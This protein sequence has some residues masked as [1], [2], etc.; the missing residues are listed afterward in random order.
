LSSSKSINTKWIKDLYIGPETLK[1]EQE[2]TGNTLEAICIGND[3]LSRTQMAQPVRKRIDKWDFMK[4]KIFFTSKETVY[5]LKRLPTEW[6][7]IFASYIADKGLVTRKFRDLKKINTQ[8]F[9][10]PMKKWA[11]ELSKTFSKE[12]INMA[13]KT[14]EEMFNIPGHKGNGNQNYIKIHLTC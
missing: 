3:F 9:N 10:D 6:E 5:K 11:K 4:L 1:I 12:E 8:K 14:H 2:S 7:K 13:K